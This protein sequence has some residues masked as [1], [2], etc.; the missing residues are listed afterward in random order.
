MVTTNNRSLWKKMWEYKDHGKSYEAVYKRKHDE[1]F[2]WLHES[3]GTNWRMTEMQAVIGRI[4]LKKIDSWHKRRLKNAICIWDAAKQCKGLRVPYVP[5]HIEHAAYKCY[6]FVEG[7]QKLRDKMMLQINEKGV[8]C[9]SGTCPEVYLE[10]AF[11]NTN[12]KPKQR[13]SNA[14]TLGETSLMFLI[15][16]TLTNKEI[17]KTCDTL[18]EVAVLNNNGI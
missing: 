6:V 15:H 2:K 3:F 4:Q 13:L 8:P 14:K 1:G 16:P 5:K 7:G 17:K 18:I 9:Y 10:K 12:F 11:N